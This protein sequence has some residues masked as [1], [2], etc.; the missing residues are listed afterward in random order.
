[1]DPVPKEDILELEERRRQCSCSIVR[2]RL[3]PVSE[4]GMREDSSWVPR[5][6]ACKSQLKME[7]PGKHVFAEKDGE[8]KIEARG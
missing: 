8:K 2:A 3:F 4:E 5:R 1:L 7:L 6:T